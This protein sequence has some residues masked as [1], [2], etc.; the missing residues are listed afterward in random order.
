MDYINPV[1]AEVSP[2]LYTAAKTAGLSRQQATQVEQM[3]YTIKKHRELSKLSADVARNVYDKLDGGIQEQLKFMFKNADYLKAEPT[4]GD[5]IRGVL[6]APLNA[7]KTPLVAALKVGGFYNQVINQPYKLAR[8]AAQGE[9]PFAYKTWKTAWDGKAVYDEG[10]LQETTDYFGKYDVEVAKGLLA[11]LTPGEIVEKY[12]TPDANILESI[13]KAFNEPEKF[14]QVL[15]GVKYSQV[16]PGRDIARMLDDKP[17]ANGGMHGDYIDGTTRKFSGVID[18]MYQIAID[19]L[20]W[21]SGGTSKFV[22]RGDKIA[23]GILSQIDS[24]VSS[25]R[26]VEMAFNKNPKLY[27]LWEDQLGPRI[28]ALSE[29]KG[30][31]AKADAYRV[32][33][34]NH[35][36]YDN[37]YAVKALVDAK[38]FDATSAKGYFENAVNLSY[39][40]SGRVN[41]VTYM[42][43]GVAVAR[44]NRNMTDN[45]MRGLDAVFNAR[46]RP[47]D[48]VKPGE[49][50]YKVLADPVDIVTRIK[51]G[52]IDL[53]AVVNSTNEIKKW[54]KI[55]KVIG[56]QAARS[57]AGLE[58][59]TG[60][61]AI[62]TAN[63]F[64]AR[65]R[66]LLPRDMAE[67]L[68]QRFLV[69]SEDEQYVILRN[70]DA[71]TMYAMGLGG[72][73]NGER[74]I[75]EILRQKYGD[76]AG[77]ATKTTSKVNEEFA[78]AAPANAVQNVDGVLESIHYGP[79]HPYQSTKAVGSLPYDEIGNMIWNIKSK[80]NLINAAGGATQGNFSRKLVDAWSILTLFPRLGIRSAIDEA[81]MYTLTAPT[82]D[83]VRFAKFQ[84]Y[85]MGNVAKSFTGSTAA[86]GPIKQGLQKIFQTEPEKNIFEILGK[87]VTINPEEAVSRQ[88]RIDAIE[89]YAD[90][91]GVDSALLTS[92][93]KR[94][95][96]GQHVANIYGRYI[97]S[98]QMQ[99]LLDAFTYSP[100]AVTSMAQ[101][102]VANSAIS[103]KFGKTVVEEM[104]TPS[105]LDN[106]LAG[107]GVKMSPKTRNLM[108]TGL[109]ESQVSLAQ[110][111]KFVK[112][113]AGNKASILEK[114]I[115]M[116]Y[117][118]PASIFFKNNGL[119]TADDVTNAL[120]D[121]M[122]AI[123]YR[124]DPMTDMWNPSITE[125]IK[126]Y[127]ASSSTT[128]E[129][130]A[131]GM[132]NDE[133]VRTRLFN[134]F[135]DMHETFHGD[136]D[137]FNQGLVDLVKNKLA[138]INKRFENSDRV[139][140]YNEAVSGISLDDFRDATQGFRIKGEISTAIDF[141]DFDAETIF[142][143]YGNNAMEWMDQQVTGIFRQPAIMVTYTQIRKKYAGLEKQFVKQQ[144]A[145]N[146]SET[147]AVSIAKQRFTEIAMRDAADTVLKYADNPSIRTNAA[148]ML[149]TT[150][151]YYRATEDFYRRIYRMKDV[152][153]RVLYRMRLAH[154][155]LS[156]N[157]MTHTDSEGEP[158]IVMPMDNI[159]F[160][161]TNGTIGVLTG[162]GL[163]GYK[164]PSFNEFTLK[165][166]MVNPSFSQDAGV[167]T[168]SGPIAALG[169]LGLRNV[170]GTLPGKLPFIGQYLD[171]PSKILAEQ[172]DTFALG[173]IGDNINVT[174]AIVPAG[175]QRVWAIIDPT[176]R[177]RQE[178]T[179]AQQAIAYNAANGDFLDPDST[180]EEKSAYLKRMR[181]T[182]HNVIALRN[183]LGLFSP[184]APTLM[185]S[186][187]V[188]DYLKDVG[189]TS[190]RAEFFDIL[191]GIIKTNNGELSDPYEQALVTY[192]GKYPGKLIYTVSR[193]AKQTEVVVKNTE[194]LKN[195]SIMN[196]D[197][198]K[199]YG[200]A[201]YIFAPQVGKFNA[202]TYNWIQAAGLMEN[203]DLETYY[204]DL[205]VAQDKQ[206]YYDIARKEKEVL[207][208]TPDAMARASIIK[209]AELGRA[210]LKNSNPL[211]EAALIGQG[212]NIGT[213]ETMLG[214]LEQMLSTAKIPV[215]SST[216]LR[217]R[218]ATKAIRN[219]IVTCK[220]IDAQGA[221]NKTQL[222][223]ELKDQVE[224][225]LK[226]LMMG[227]LYVT[228]A[229]RAIFRSILNFYSRDSYYATRKM[230]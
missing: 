46:R 63:N 66:H 23:N 38:V 68:T 143:K 204:N 21:L 140:S 116:V 78:K 154:L 36:G 137:L 133:I 201:A 95:A 83:L 226:E 115:P 199:N 3:S 104:I 123:G 124:F 39:L 99:Y 210:A 213:E 60:E 164:Q 215:D 16:S 222:K 67:A 34:E 135:R 169:V 42:R 120:D 227:D 208:N 9:N 170:L 6:L 18:F 87:K 30:A 229:N 106:A 161:A 29:A 186:K 1:V 220:S 176:E 40:M 129:L 205:L 173:N 11:G 80:K 206:Y 223:A 149:R 49:D 55:A 156:A 108:T 10:A 148:Y 174:K 54:R 193:D 218:T 17:P 93:E 101:S 109:T 188:P 92:L 113:F 163:Q 107:L 61:A 7:L 112:M 4:S 118:N 76:A 69:A 139:A 144:M 5:F 25:A 203:K 142:R 216:I 97:D 130:R 180:N 64:T 26:A 147:M 33:K 110:Y 230:A 179:A 43:N 117:L 146:V 157:G 190:L 14:K 171:E 27:T 159:I 195:W 41:G 102:L 166:R 158:Y 196:Q 221:S 165:L 8:L 98:E 134:M 183:V 85:K 175:L 155:G 89:K 2:N 200:E 48:I 35:P 86:T 13:K 138:Q 119:K 132:S 121:A 24:G 47:E 31:E 103:G 192:T 81:V 167:P 126:D 228:E 53:P 111:E 189:I 58:V 122:Y 152:P 202:A 187:G 74:L 59:R 197:F 211:L 160:K 185:E 212:N 12:G 84:G 44:T 75:N 57:P 145:A 184:V 207:A 136:A 73:V 150:G 45:L 19:P 22:T 172:V 217:M 128:V 219:Y 127:L 50:L 168:L 72:D 198:I 77:F 65:A 100:D 15:D 181:I 214:T 96:V 56:K 32:I 51:S 191:N 82:Q 62:L 151:R 20:T 182:A 131:L 91:K 177:S 178:V 225:T 70:L 105:M 71:S 94:E 28:K 153:F 162:Q 125:T 88:A 79:I 141:G 114:G 37:P 194:E 52:D 209:Q 224:A 90:A